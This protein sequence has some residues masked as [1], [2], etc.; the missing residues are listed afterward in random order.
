VKPYVFHPEAEREVDEAMGRL[1]EAAPVY[2]EDFLHDLAETIRQIREFPEIGG[3]FHDTYRRWSVRRF[4]YDV[5]YRE[6]ES[7][8]V[9]IA[10]AHQHRLPG[11]WARRIETDEV[12][13][14]LGTR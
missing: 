14:P 9:V 1:A 12:R 7:A 10:M 4:H 6:A 8:I 13:E 5:I 11:Y 2:A 3:S